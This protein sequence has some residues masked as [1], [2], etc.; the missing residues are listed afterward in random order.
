MA[1][2]VKGE[3]RCARRNKGEELTM[4]DKI[5][6]GLKLGIPIVVGIIIATLQPPEMLDHSAMVYM[7][8]F[9]CVIVWLIVDVMPDWAAVT[10]AMASFVVFG[11]TNLQGAFAPFA[12]TTIWLVIG[13]FGLAAVVSKTGLLKRI[14]FFVSSLFPESYKGQVG[15]L[16][17][18][19]IVMSPLIPALVA[20]GAILA[21]L[22]TAI[23]KSLGYVKSSKAASGMFCAAW[24]SAG[25][26]GCAFLTGAAPCFIIIGMLPTD[27]QAN[28]TV[29]MNWFLAAAVWFVVIAVLCY[30][31]IL[32]LY[33]PAKEKKAAGRKEANSD[34][35]AAAS[36]ASTAPEIE[37]GFA[38]RQLRE[39]GPMS[40]EEKIAG[41]LLVLAL[42][43]WVFG[44]NI[45][46]SNVVVTLIVF[47]LAGVTKL[48]TKNDVAERIPWGTVI[49]IGGVISLASLISKLGIDKWLG[50]VMGPFIQPFASNP[51]LF[52]LL[53]CVL[54]YLLRFAIISQ[55]ATMAIFLAAL[56]GVA[57]ASGINLWVLLFVCYMASHVWHFP[58]TNNVYVA[59]LGSTNGQ[60]CEHKDTLPMNWAYMAI[61]LVACLAS[62]P[63]WQMMG[64]M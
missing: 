25:I 46:L 34:A 31:A 61:N 27:Q 9:E 24:V 37:H 53:I 10:I 18:T 48:L 23:S 7:G 49:F 41:A 5:A 26:L 57:V 62:V 17:T 44:S 2:T 21:P 58:F 54:T 36:S 64:L 22:A 52:I 33:N 47:A 38:K 6:V 63:V 30:V 45:G 14:A 50:T 35:G 11:L 40:R 15:A 4:K 8:I 16:Y 51:Y 28:W 3:R 55:T 20:K 59:V 32:V 39:M 42:V 56:S 19:G 60:I 12:D 1:I 13:A 43:G 29:W